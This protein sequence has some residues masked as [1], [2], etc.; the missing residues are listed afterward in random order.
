MDLEMK[1]T[2]GGGG[3]LIGGAR[4]ASPRRF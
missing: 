3:R 2:G 1:V 4:R